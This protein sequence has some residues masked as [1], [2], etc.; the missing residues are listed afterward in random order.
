MQESQVH[1]ALP[2]LPQ[3]FQIQKNGQPYQLSTADNLKSVN[4]GKTLARYQAKKVVEPF[5][6]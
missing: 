3:Y 6:L 1:A 5:K 2:L 4:N